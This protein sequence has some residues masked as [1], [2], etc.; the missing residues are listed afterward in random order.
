MHIHEIIL[1]SVYSVFIIEFGD[2]RKTI[3]GEKVGQVE[4]VTLNQIY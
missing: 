2:L 4:L 3:R 1:R